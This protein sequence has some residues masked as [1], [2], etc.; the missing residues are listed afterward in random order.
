M[1]DVKTIEVKLQKSHGWD[2]RDLEDLAINIGYSFVGQ[3]GSHRKYQHEVCRLRPLIIPTNNNLKGTDN[4]LI[5]ILRDTW[6]EMNKPTEVI[7]MDVKQ[8]K[9]GAWRTMIRDTREKAS[10]GLRQVGEMMGFSSNVATTNIYEY[11][12]AKRCFTRLEFEC[13]CKVFH[14]N[15]AEQTWMDEF[16]ERQEIVNRRNALLTT[17]V[18]IPEVQMRIAADPSPVVVTPVEK[19]IPESLPVE[20]IFKET[21]A[22]VGKL[23]IL[24]IPAMDELTRDK[25]KELEDLINAGEAAKLEYERLTEIIQNAEEARPQLESILEWMDEWQRRIGLI[26]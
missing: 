17:P 15:P 1:Y 24:D 19:K 21:E 26:K 10:L 5:G 11:E 22:S 14:L 12:K 8:N 4:T 16:E 13:W 7:A 2:W 25:I 6:N 23:R 18:E 3:S 9:P 20:V